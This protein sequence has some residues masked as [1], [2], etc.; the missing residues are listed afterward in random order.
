[1]I[2]LSRKSIIID[3]VL[4][5]IQADSMTTFWSKDKKEYVEQIKRY[6]SKLP[7]NKIIQKDKKLFRLVGDDLWVK[8]LP[9]SRSGLAFDERLPGE[10]KSIVLK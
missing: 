5:N 4:K 1:M 6:L 7:K 10:W 8:R 2:P 9:F 3:A